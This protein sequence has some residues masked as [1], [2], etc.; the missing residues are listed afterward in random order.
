MSA[1]YVAHNDELLIDIDEPQKPVRGG[2]YI[3]KFFRQ[4]LRDAI[5]AGLLAVHDVWI[6]PS[7]T[8]GH[9]HIAVQLAAPLPILERLVWQQHLGSDLYRG[10][11]D[12]MRLARGKPAPSLL[13][14][15]EPIPRFYREPDYVC[16]CT[17][18]HDTA[19]QQALGDKACP[20][21]L[22]VRGLSPWELF[23]P[24]SQEPELCVVLPR[25]GRVPAAAIMA[26]RVRAAGSTRLQPTRTTNVAARGK[27]R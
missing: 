9:V 14:E 11:S 24:S 21:W 10:K 20:V 4:R 12:L 15:A 6:V 5:R 1:W 2:P 17:R 25:S 3:E 23:G 18:K 13:I 7:T 19:E 26:R 8:N 27:R 16:P 22:D